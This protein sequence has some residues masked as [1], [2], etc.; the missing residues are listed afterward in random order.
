MLFSNF[1]GKPPSQAGFD[2]ASCLSV[3][4]WQPISISATLTRQYQ[5]YTFQFACQ[6]QV[7]QEGGDTQLIGCECQQLLTQRFQPPNLDIQAQAQ[8]H[9]QVYQQSS[10]GPL[11]PSQMFGT[12]L[13]YG[14]YQP[15]ILP[16]Q[17]Q[18]QM[19]QV[20]SSRYGSTNES[21]EMHRYQQTAGLWRKRSHLEDFAYDS[22]CLQQLQ[23][24]VD[25]GGTPISFEPITHNPNVQSQPSAFSSQVL[26]QRPSPQYTR[27]GQAL[28]TLL[29]QLQH[30]HHHKLPSQGRGKVQRTGHG[31]APSAAEEHCSLSTV[32]QLGMPAPAARPNG[33]KLRF[34]SDDDALLI[35]LKETDNLTWRQIAD[36]FPSRSSGTLQVRYCTKLSQ[37]HRVDGRDG[38]SRRCRRRIRAH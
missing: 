32:A 8:P 5:D 16:S 19:V 36:F 26:Y 33:P 27:S 35:N 18:Q 31:E 30:Y 1:P 3:E 29:I 34:T 28:H 12:E 23:A 22:P 15:Q 21:P 13:S 10:I 14:Q 9:R 7:H 11:P 24:H 20:L 37:G 4:P 17:T 2:V 6:A 38:T 25:S